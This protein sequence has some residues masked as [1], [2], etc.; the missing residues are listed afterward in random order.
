MTKEDVLRAQD[1]AEQTRVQFKD[2]QQIWRKP[3]T[4]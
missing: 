3:L 2:P 1:T 4:T